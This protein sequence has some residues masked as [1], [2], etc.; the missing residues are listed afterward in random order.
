M[1]DL[2]SLITNFQGKGKCLTGYSGRMKLS[3][4]KMGN[5]VDR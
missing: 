1:P 4:T 3:F 2:L 5:T